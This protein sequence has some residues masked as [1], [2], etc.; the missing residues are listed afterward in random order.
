MNQVVYYQIAVATVGVTVHHLVKKDEYDKNGYASW[1]ALYEWYDGDNTKKEK[2]YY[3]RYR[4]ES[5]GLIS[6]SKSAQYINI[7]L[8]SFR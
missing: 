6:A 2:S 1:K 3:F 5:Y 7:F 8:T 4:L